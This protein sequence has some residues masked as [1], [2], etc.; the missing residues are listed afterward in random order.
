MMPQMDDDAM[1]ALMD[2]SHDLG[3]YLRLPLAMLP[4]GAGPAEVKGA[5]ETALLR[6]RVGPTGIRAAREIWDGLRAEIAGPLAGSPG[7]Q[8]LEDAVERALGWERTLDG[9][10]EIDRAAVT[11][12]FEAVAERIRALIGEVTRG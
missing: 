10:G 9:G 4:D 12:D 7:F 6:T 8:D 11:A 1:D 3:K 2:L 5:V